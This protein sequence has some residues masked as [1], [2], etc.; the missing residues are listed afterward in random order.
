MCSY[1][2]K[3]VCVCSEVLAE[4][5]KL[6]H[7]SLMQPA[8]GRKQQNVPFDED[9]VLVHIWMYTYIT[10]FQAGKQIH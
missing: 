8:H 3:Y 6:L 10:Y 7:N 4:V 9:T 2:L 5:I 1:S